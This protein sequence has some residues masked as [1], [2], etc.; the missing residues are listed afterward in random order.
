MNRKVEAVFVLFFIS[1]ASGLV[2][3]SVW[4]HYLKLF[5]GH[6][7]YAQTLVLVVFIGGLA[8]GS[9]LCSRVAGRIRNPLRLYAMIEAATGLLALV[10]HSIFVS[11]VDWGYASLLPAA[12]EQASAFCPA[13]WLLASLLLAPQSILLGAT[14]PLAS[15][16]VL[17]MEGGEPGHHISA[18]YFLNSMGAVLG[19]LGSAFV[20][21]P[22]WGLPGALRVA[23]LAN[24]AIA[25]VAFL[26]SQVPPAPLAVERAPAVAGQVTQRRLRT[27]LL[28]AALI[29]GLSSFIYEIAWIRM[30]SLVLGASTHS[31]ELMLASFILGLALGGGWIRK[32]IDSIGDPVRFL[33]LVQLAMGVAAVATIPMYNASFD[34]MAWF[35]S[36]VARNS[37]G[38]VLFNVVSTV[39]ALAVMLPATICAGMTLPLI[40]YRL[41]RSES[42]ERALG[43]VYSVNTLGSIVGVILAVHFLLPWLGLH[44]TLVAGAAID[45]ALGVLLLSMTGQ[46]ERRASS[47]R[48]AA[49][50]VAIL[51]IIAIALPIDVRR[52]SSGV[53]RTGAARIARDNAIIFHRDGKTATVDVMDDTH[54]RSIRTNG[55]PDAALTMTAD[56]PPMGDEITMALLATLPL[57]HNPQAKRAAVIG[58]GSGMSTS[59]LLASPHLERV[60]TVEIEPA[61]VEGARN[62]QPRVD[63]A[64]NDPRSHIVVDDAKSYFSRGHARYD[65]IVSEPS[66]PWVSGVASL[67]SE[68]FYARLSNYLEDGGVLSQWLHTYEMDEATLAS[69]FS[70][71]AKTFPDFVVYSSI[72]SDIILVARKGGAPGRFDASVL[73]WP[74]LHPSLERLRLADEGV[75]G[76]RAM[77]SAA[78]VQRLFKAY[79]MSANSDYFPVVDQRASKTRFT[80]TRVGELTELQ[81]SAVPMLEMLDG[82]F[83]PAANRAS[84]YSLTLADAAGAEAWTLHDVVTGRGAPER[85][86][87]QEDSR[88]LA[89]RLVRAWMTSCS[90]D[91]SFE[92]MLPSFVSVAEIANPHLPAPA[93]ADLWRA[94]NESACAKRLPQGER[95]WLELFAAVGRR[96]APGMA[97]QG[98]RLLNAAPQVRSSATELAFIAAVTGLVCEGE[99][100]PANTV[101]EQGTRHWLRPGVRRTELRYLH[102]LANDPFVP[103][104]GACAAGRPT[105]RAT[106]SR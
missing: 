26:I 33:G 37:G 16:A 62:F 97:G 75:I 19:V 14:F 34:L 40:T 57:G 23:G 66:N 44:L 63:A 48:L 68:E 24:L 12:C 86:D 41:L 35:L 76:R 56:R 98:V 72:D 30:L 102:T 15:S 29:T 65:I 104:Y 4:S 3:E 77:G 53:F 89:A 70:A 74:A 38:F 64:F 99:M 21:I 91:L 47:G 36:S 83:T 80:Q 10:F 17:R 96:D 79:G 105:A 43:L 58:F 84:T 60:D 27:L 87:S 69:I 101:L 8:L 39:I 82:S 90:P 55:K 95:G 52:S 61:M 5:L 54:V 7:A 45:V 9:W 67:F 20:L 13:Q 31:F 6:A 22:G 51:A 92:K 1:G 28:S 106:G 94:V 49:G 11:A 25:S 42:G 100:G 32:R 93:A 2:Y 73:Q 18:L 88:E 85:P 59:L 71:V 50:A 78:S 46:R 103:A 81:S